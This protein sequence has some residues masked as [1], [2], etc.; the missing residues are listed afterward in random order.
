MRPTIAAALGIV[1]VLIATSLFVP[2]LARAGSLT[3]DHGA[4]PAVTQVTIATTN[5]FGGVRNSF[6][7]GL[8]SGNVYFAATDTSADT[9]ATVQ[10]N[11]H[12]ASRDAVSSPAKSWTV[13][14]QGNANNSYTW[15]IYYQLP[16]NLVYGG[17]WNIT[18]SGAAGGFAHQ[19]FTVQTYFAES[20]LTPRVS[21]PAQNVSVPILIVKSVNSAPYT[22]VTGVV[23]TGEYVTTA[24]VFAKLPN[25]PAKLGAIVAG[26]YNFTIPTDA[27]GAIDLVVY[28]NTSSNGFNTSVTAFADGTVGRLS[29]PLVTLSS[30]PTGCPS[31]SFPSGTP[32]YVLVHE[33]ISGIPGDP[34]TGMTAAFKFEKGSSFVT[35]PGNPPSS[36]TIDGLGS[37]SVTFLASASVF[38]TTGLNTVV[39]TVTDPNDP[40]LTSQTTNAS[41]TIHNVTTRP[42]VLVTWSSSEYYSGAVASFH[43]A[44]GGQ[45]ASVTAGWNGSY[46]VVESF[47]G[48]GFIDL[49]RIAPALTSGTVTVTLPKTFIGLVLAFVYASNATSAV[50]STAET[51]VE[52]GTILLT[53][54]ELDY[55]PGDTVHISVITNGGALAGA[56]FWGTVVDRAGNWIMNSAVSGNSISVSVPSNSPPTSY[57]ITVT[58]QTATGGT[59]ANATLTIYESS[60]ID[61]NLGISTASNYLDGSYQPGETVTVNYAF[62]ARGQASLPQTYALLLTPSTDQ[63][64]NYAST[65]VDLT[66]SS[67]TFQ[68]T[69]PKD[70][71]N[72]ILMVSAQAMLGGPN[73]NINC[74]SNSQFTA[75]VNGN[76]AALSYQF[77]NSGFTLGA[78]IAIVVL[79]VLA[80]IV[81]MVMRRRMGGRPVMMKPEATSTTS[82]TSGGSSGGTPPT[83]TP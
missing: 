36:V 64:T 75:T 1:A 70:A 13:H 17:Q 20:A 52:A 65:S 25:T 43:W 27:L 7:V 80:L 34:A 49:G 37:A 83:S 72:G 12:N 40:A 15:G 76:P 11:D 26:Y 63:N 66:S 38:S 73:C 9:T 8:G 54:S 74:Q 3:P 59:I 81:F 30:C 53:A 33:Y 29:A 2:G 67:G 56:T 23:V 50:G 18:I 4:T 62:T 82:A 5:D 16:L 51:D 68:Y 71:P 39:V 78:L 28:A 10:I 42:S 61:L 47:T 45:N 32:V 21:L 69:I 44:L 6:V 46:W 48:T 58:A 35:P 55:L 14:L 24:S 41:F 31:G 57:T 19:N 60:G 79:L 77:G 22:A